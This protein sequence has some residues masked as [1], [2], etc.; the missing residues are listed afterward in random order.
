M[1]QHNRTGFR[2]PGRFPFPINGRRSKQP[3]PIVGRDPKGHDNIT[4]RASFPPWQH[5]ESDS[6]SSAP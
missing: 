5:R 4:G 6:R 2:E 3:F 1:T